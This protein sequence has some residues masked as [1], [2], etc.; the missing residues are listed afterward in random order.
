MLR[1]N[2]A[3]REEIIAMFILDPLHMKTSRA[4]RAKQ[5]GIIL[6]RIFQNITHFDILRVRRHTSVKAGKRVENTERINNG[7]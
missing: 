2:S 4:G 5:K 1:R 3:G 7:A 6:S